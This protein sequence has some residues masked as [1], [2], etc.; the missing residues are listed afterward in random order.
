MS[1]LSRSILG[2]V[3]LAA[4]VVPA[5]A[6]APLLL[7]IR[8]GQVTLKAQNVPVRTILMEWARIGGTNVVGA[9]R[10]TGAPVTM[11]LTGVPERQALDVLLRTASG[12]VLGMRPS[13]VQ[14]ASA[15]NRILIMPPST[16]P[17]ALPNPTVAGG[18]RAPINIPE[19]A[20]DQADVDLDN[21]GPQ[22]RPAPPVRMPTVTGQSLPPT[23]GQPPSTPPLPDTSLPI[24]PQGPGTPGV[25]PGNPFG[26][27]QGSSSSPGVIT[28]A[29]PQP[30]RAPD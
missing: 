27:P 10:M 12:Y 26:I 16:A 1:L 24:S 13:G 11:E 7:D 3:A 20:E 4:V 25:T 17:R 15:Y 19:P 22:A 23:G 2:L 18:G 5:A 21:P 9:D 14:G 6:Q 30:Q 28:P 29:P 8:D